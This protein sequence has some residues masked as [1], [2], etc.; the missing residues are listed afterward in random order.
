MPRHAERDEPG[1]AEFGF[2]NFAGIAFGLRIQVDA[3]SDVH[4]L[5]GSLSMML[6]GFGRRNAHSAGVEASTGLLACGGLAVPFGRV[7]WAPI[8]PSSQCGRVRRFKCRR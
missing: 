8:K 5:V 2:K 6:L 3:S 4:G 7:G 1:G